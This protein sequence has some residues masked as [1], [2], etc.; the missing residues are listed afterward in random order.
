MVSLSIPGLLG[1]HPDLCNQ[2]AQCHANAMQDNND[3]TEPNHDEP[4]PE[5]HTV[6]L[7]DSPL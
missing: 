6:L 2:P 7:Y 4:N 1:Y 3:K 5:R